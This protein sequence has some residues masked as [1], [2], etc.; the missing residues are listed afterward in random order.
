MPLLI[1]CLMKKYMSQKLG[2]KKPTIVPVHAEEAQGKN[3]K[4][5]CGVLVSPQVCLD[6]S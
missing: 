1:F 2:D 3:Q 6:P 5:T 4:L